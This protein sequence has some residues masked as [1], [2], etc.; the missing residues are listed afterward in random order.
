MRSILLTA[1]LLCPACIL[2]AASA[3]PPCQLS[4]DFD[5]DGLRDEFTGDALGWIR[6]AF[7]SGTAASAQIPFGITSCEARDLDGD[8]DLDAYVRGDVQQAAG[9]RWE[10]GRIET[11]ATMAERGVFPSWLKP[12]KS[13]SGQSGSPFFGAVAHMP[14][15]HARAYPDDSA[16]RTEFGRPSTLRSWFAMMRFAWRRFIRRRSSSI[17]SLPV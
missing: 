7:A 14:R 16:C 11:V 6:Y 3:G 8:G 4:V 1:L 17:T 15:L 12:R 9:F 5:G 2:D 10:S 13:S